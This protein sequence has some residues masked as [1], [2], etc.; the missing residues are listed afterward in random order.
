MAADDFF[1]VPADKVLNTNV[2]SND[3]GTAPT[4]YAWTMVRQPAYL[5]PGSTTPV[6]L[7]GGFSFSAAGIV[8]FSPAAAGNL[9]PGT[10]VTFVYL[11]TNTAN[12][13][14]TNNATVT[15]TVADPS[16]PFPPTP[17]PAAGSGKAANMHGFLTAF[18]R[19]AIHQLLFYVARTPR[20]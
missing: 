3:T 11:V 14:R 15:I 4:G 5:T 16:G 8:S 19:G 17:P 13:V 12:G 9:K 10:V 6:P 7:S 1:T 18:V 20:T 2:T